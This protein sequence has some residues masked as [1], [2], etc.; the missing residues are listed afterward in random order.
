MY[1]FKILCEISK[2]PFEITQ[3]FWTH[4]STIYDILKLWHLK[5]YRGGG[6]GGGN[7]R[8]DMG[9]IGFTDE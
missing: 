7:G 5:Y 8:V 6:G 9:F 4:T 1:G 2:V 3:K